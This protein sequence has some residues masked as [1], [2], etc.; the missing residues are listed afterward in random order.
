M[1]RDRDVA[2]LC[3]ALERHARSGDLEPL[4]KHLE[5]DGEL[6]AELKVLLAEIVRRQLKFARG[7]RRTFAQERREIRIRNEVRKLQTEEARL[8][9]TRG[10]FQ[11][12]LNRYR[13]LDPKISEEQ[14]RTYF[15]RGGRVLSKSEQA[16]LD[17][18]LCQLIDTMEALEHQEGLR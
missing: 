12:A 1:S 16:F 2:V 7:N 3:W 6:T 4:A 5:A 17:E 15:K 8:R 9:G 13:D 14:L 11:R 10:S 18:C